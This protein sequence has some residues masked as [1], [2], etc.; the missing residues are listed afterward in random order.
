MNMTTL[1]NSK[2]LPRRER[3]TGP[4]TF[5]LGLVICA[6][7]LAVVSSCNPQASEPLAPASTPIPATDTPPAASTTTRTSSPVLSIATQVFA[8]DGM[9][10]SKIPAGA[11]LMGSESGNNN[12]KPS[13]LVSLDAFWMDQTEVTNAMYALCVQS[14]GCMPAGGDFDDP[15]L[16]DF[17]VVFVTW[18]MASAYC[19]WAGRRLPTEAEWERAARGGLEGAGYP[20]GDSTP[21]CAPGVVN[22]AQFYACDGDATA[23]GRFAPNNFALYDMAGNVWEWVADW[24]DAAYYST[25]PEGVTNP[26]G[27]ETGEYKVLRGGSWSD[28]LPVILRVSS[29]DRFNPALSSSVTGFRCAANDLP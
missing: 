15:A 11:F 24:Y 13:H 5:C 16:A 21:S 25:L 28:Q 12:E 4:R 19:A 9:V 27:P 20:W 8:V 22:G 26:P 18:D 3:N 17:P 23:V 2:P 6:G 10:T 1:D 7:L 14:E 29:R